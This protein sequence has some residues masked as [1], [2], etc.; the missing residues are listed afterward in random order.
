MGL[1]SLP[2]EATLAMIYQGYGTQYKS[3][4]HEGEVIGRTQ[5]SD[6]RYTNICQWEMVKERNKQVLM[7]NVLAQ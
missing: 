6:G 7:K 1:R 2:E 3:T 4:G 5:D